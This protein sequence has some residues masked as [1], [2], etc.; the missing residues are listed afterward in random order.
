MENPNQRRRSQSI[1]DFGALD[2]DFAGGLEGFQEGGDVGFGEL[3]LEDGGDGVGEGFDGAGAGGV[4]LLEAV[5]EDGEAFG[6]GLSGG[7]FEEGDVVDG[8]EAGGEDAFGLQ[9]FDEGIE[10]GVF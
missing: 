10:A 7:G 2:G 1:G 8:F 9:V 5:E 3:L 4:Y 6:G